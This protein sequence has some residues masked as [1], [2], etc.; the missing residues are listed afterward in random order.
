[1]LIP[2]SLQKENYALS[3]SSG[4]ST[5]STADSTYYD[6]TNMSVSLTV[7]GQKPVWVGLI[8]DLAGNGC[9]FEI[10]SSTFPVQPKFRF[11]RNGSSIYTGRHTVNDTTCSITVFGL[12]L[13]PGVLQ[14]V[15]L[16]PTSGT[17]TYKFQTM[18]DTAGNTITIQNA[19]LLAIELQY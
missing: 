2:F 6:V 18:V 11:T 9:F 13:P 3:S 12:R 14:V 5:N 4:T 8:P 15:D 7:S 10:Y 16:E 19:K 17:H 1:M